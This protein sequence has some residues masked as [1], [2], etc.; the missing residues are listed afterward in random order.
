MSEELLKKQYKDSS[1]LNSRIR[2]HE[3]FSTNKIDWHLWL[4]EQYK[5]PKNSCI[6]E[7]GCGNGVFWAKNKHRIPS[8]WNIVLSDFSSGMLKDAQKNLIEF[9]NIQ[10]KQ[11]E[12]QNIPF[13]DN[14]FDVVIAN[15]MLYHVPNRK[16]AIQEVRRV[17]KSNGVF[18]A[19][20][21]GN[22]HMA[23]T[24]ELLKSFDPKLIYS[25]SKLSDKFGL[26]NGQEQLS[27]YFSHVSLK[28]FEGGLEVTEVQP[29]AQYLLS[30]NS[31]TK[32][33]L[34]GEKLGEFTKFLKNRMQ[35][36]GG[37]I[38]ITKSTG[39]FEAF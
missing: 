39:L 27:K 26:E 24:V 34:M 13:E 28:E 12:A 33:I 32:E 1:N 35:E 16:K 18:Y 10:Y 17:L 8:D 37:L 36:S 7:L 23:E 14:S 5:I 19:A 29:L 31:N 21:N 9:E 6:L 38:Y 11:I 3:L 20:T 25:P 30:T 4:F 22:K 2:I 15:H